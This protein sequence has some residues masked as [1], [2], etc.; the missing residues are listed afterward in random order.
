MNC[1]RYYLELDTRDTIGDIIYKI[2]E[3]DGVPS[4]EQRIILTRKDEEGK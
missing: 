1:M 4:Y 2:E 3:K